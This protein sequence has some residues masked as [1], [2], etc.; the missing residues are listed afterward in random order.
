[1]LG[2]G[3][4]HFL[5]LDLVLSVDQLNRGGEGGKGRTEIR[6]ETTISRKGDVIGRVCDR[7]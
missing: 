3:S 7:S 4:D 5:I 2:E 1:M 6:L